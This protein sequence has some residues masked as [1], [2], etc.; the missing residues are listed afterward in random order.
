MKKFINILTRLQLE[1]SFD[2]FHESPIRK[3][4]DLSFQNLGSEL[5]YDLWL[6]LYERFCTPLPSRRGTCTECPARSA[7]SPPREPEK[8]WFLVIF[9][10]FWKS[11]GWFSRSKNR[12]FDTFWVILSPDLM[13]EHYQ[14][15]P[16]TFWDSLND[17][18]KIRIFC[19]WE[20]FGVINLAL[21][22]IYIMS[23]HPAGPEKSGFLVIF[24]NFLKILRMIF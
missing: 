17:F 11:F 15:T 10:I 21:R 9:S 20:R 12:W 14:L 24:F 7:G 2:D 6:F 3:V 8:S 4:R 16:E 1:L 19:A 22:F 13:K 5:S 18:K 23:I